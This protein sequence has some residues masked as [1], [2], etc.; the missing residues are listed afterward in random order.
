[1]V[2]KSSDGIVSFYEKKHVY[3][4]KTLGV[5]TSVTTLVKNCF[6]KF[7]AKTISK[8]AAIKQTRER[9]YKVTPS[10]LRKEWKESG[11]IASSKGSLVHAEIEQFIKDRDY[12]LLEVFHPLSE[13]G[14]H[15]VAHYLDTR[16]KIE[17]VPEELLYN[18][19]YLIAGQADLVVY[20]EDNTVDIIDWKTN[21]LIN[22]KSK[23]G[24]KGLTEATKDLQDCNYVH[25]N[26]QL[27]IYAYLLELEG[28]KVGRLLIPHLTDDGVVLYELDYLRDTVISL[29]EE[30]K[31]ET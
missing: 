16:N 15:W 13:Y 10:M 28:F 22:K 20:Y 29:L 26:L 5:L 7:D 4:H 19:D 2:K 24:K 3:K 30:F 9:G 6:P 21:R 12:S 11:L 8:Y 27:S 14:C 23:Y 18:E 25:Y 1:M 17:P 31:N